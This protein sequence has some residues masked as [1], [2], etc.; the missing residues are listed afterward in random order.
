ME[1]QEDLFRMAMHSSWYVDVGFSVATLPAQA[2]RLQ[3]FPL[4]P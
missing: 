2:Q 4:C 1:I 3:Y